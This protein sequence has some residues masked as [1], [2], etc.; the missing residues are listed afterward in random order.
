MRGLMKRRDADRSARALTLASTVPLDMAPFSS[1]A[2]RLAA[3]HT[4][5][6]RQA[7]IL[8]CVCLIGIWANHTCAHMGCVAS[9]DWQQQWRLVKTVGANLTVSSCLSLWYPHSPL[10]STVLDGATTGLDF[11]RTQI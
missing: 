6:R 8:H 7:A 1:A 3:R 5:N 9:I 11:R 4:S 10:F 2:G